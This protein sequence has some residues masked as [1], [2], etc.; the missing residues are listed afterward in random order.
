[1]KIPSDSEKL[2]QAI[3]KYML[4]QTDFKTPREITEA[5]GEDRERKGTIMSRYRDLIA[6]GYIQHD[7][8]VTR[9]GYPDLIKAYKLGNPLYTNGLLFENQNEVNHENNMR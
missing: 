6:M 5:I 8:W 3:V 4:C 2:R 7:A 1:M 9:P